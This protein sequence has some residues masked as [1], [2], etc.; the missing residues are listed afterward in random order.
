[1]FYHFGGIHFMENYYITENKYLSTALSFLGFRY[2]IFNNTKT[3]NVK[4]YGFIDSQELQQAL[5]ELIQIKR[6]YNK[7]KI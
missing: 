2:Y 7:Y 6:K 3:T 5:S 4:T 1:M